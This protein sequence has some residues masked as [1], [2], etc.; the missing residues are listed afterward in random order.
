M[1]EVEEF[2]ILPLL[3]LTLH[4]FD[5][6]S[7]CSNIHPSFIHLLQH[8]FINHSFQVYDEAAV[9]RGSKCTWMFLETYSV[10]VLPIKEASVNRKSLFASFLCRDCDWNRI[11]ATRFKIKIRCNSCVWNFSAWKIFWSHSKNSF[12][13]LNQAAKIFN[14]F[15]SFSDSCRI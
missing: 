2:S 12:L 14:S 4:P 13:L 3:H 11:M 6:S 10:S 15:G 8:P 7:V 5:P 1:S 9:H